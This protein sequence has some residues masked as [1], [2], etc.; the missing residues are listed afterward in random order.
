MKNHRTVVLAFVVMSLFWLVF[1]FVSWGSAGTEGASFLNIP[2][3]GRPA[4]LGS[5]YTSQATDAYAP[6]W[7]P[8]GLGFVEAN[9]VSGQHLSYLESIHYEYLSLVHPLQQVRDSQVHRAWGASMQ[10]LG[11]GDIA[12]TNE[13]GD[14]IGSFSAHFG[15]Y[16]LAYGQTLTEKLAVGLTAKW[17]NAKISD[18]SANA[19]AVDFGTLYRMTSKL[20][21]AGT[22]T[23]VGNQLKFISEGDSLP[24]ALHFGGSYQV[25]PKVALMSD[26]EY[27][28][29]GIASWHGG[30]E[31]Q[32][33]GP[34]ALRVGYKTDTLKGLSPLAG[35]TTGIGIKVSNA[36]FSYAWA[37]YGELGNAQY[38]SLNL[39]FG[40][41]ADKKRQLI[42]YQNIKPPATVDQKGK[43]QDDQ[44][45]MELLKDQPAP[46]AKTP[47]RHKKPKKVARKPASTKSAG[48]DFVRNIEQEAAQRIAHGDSQP[49][50]NQNTD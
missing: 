6:T 14:S 19:F 27:Q 9:E 37:P 42:Q 43:A 30:A 35:L 26:V 13:H 4:A 31:W 34:I 48:D 29:T 44:Q 47:V 7:N 49:A 18:V 46:E 16:N 3:G 32:P 12:A 20:T 21:L 11:S 28:K 41:R 22:L 40:G 10:Y 8:A 45:L 24:L 39:R 38:F 25:H 1:P 36:E 5:A 23:N 2:V 17:I 50:R 33:I 15:S